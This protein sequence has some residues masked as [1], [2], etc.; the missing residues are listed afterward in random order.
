MAA[1]SAPRGLSR[2]GKRVCVLERGREVLPG[3][4]PSRFPE[5]KNEFLVRGRKY[6]A[7][8]PAALYDV[9]LGDDMHVVVANGLGGGSLVNGGVA[10]AP[11]SARVRRPRLA[12]PD[13][14][15]RHCS[16]KATPAPI[17][18]CARPATRAPPR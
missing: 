8:S 1:A 2:A 13:R 10:L 14:A 3:E 15:G 5:L 6:S 16:T 18:G 9:R 17:G 4:F 11:R 12:R 7:G